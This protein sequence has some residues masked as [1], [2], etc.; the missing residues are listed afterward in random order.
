MRE[1][2]LAILNKGKDQALSLEG[3]MIEREAADC[4]LLALTN[5]TLFTD[6]RWFIPSSHM[7]DWQ[8]KQ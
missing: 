2:H 5:Q 4:L 7:K 1:I 6:Q 8:K 3:S